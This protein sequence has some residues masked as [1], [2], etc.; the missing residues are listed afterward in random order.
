MKL[1]Q[2]L[3]DHMVAHHGVAADASDDALKS[4]VASALVAGKLSTKELDEMT[5]DA[6][7][8]AKI[9]G[10]V[11]E[12]VTPMFADLT[13]QMEKLVGMATHHTS[14]GK[15]A[16]APAEHNAEKAK[17]AAEFIKAA[18]ID[19]Q[20][21]QAGEVRVK[22]ASE[23]YEDTRS[24]CVWQKAGDVGEYASGK[25]AFIWEGVEGGS[26]GTPR[27]IDHPSRLQEAKGAAY[28]KLM[29]RKQCPE[30]RGRIRIS[31]HEMDLIKETIHE[32][33][34]IGAMMEKGACLNRRKLSDLE[35]KAVLDEA[36][37]SVGAEV[38]PEF[39]DDAIIR[40]PLLHGELAPYVEYVPVTRGSSA[41]SASIG[42]PTFVSTASGTAITPFNTA[43]YVTAFD[44]NFYPASC[45]VQFGN[46]FLEDATPG[47]FNA[48][49][50][51]I[52]EES[53]RWLDEQIAVGDGTT[54][55][56]GIFTASGTAV[57]PDS[58]HTFSSLTYADIVTL[59][60]GINKAA[61]NAFGGSYTRFVMNDP[62]YK[63]LMQ[64]ATGVT[65]DTRPVFGVMWKEYM[66]GD[67]P[68]SVQN[69]ISNGNL[70]LCNLRGYRMYR[71][72][73]LSFITDNV[74][75]THRLADLTTLL[76]RMRWGGKITLAST[77][78]AE[79]TT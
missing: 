43:S 3:R 76:G 59:A 65:G 73:G 60:F 24:G 54:E 64:L 42:T 30:L 35:V 20:N 66:L 15:P 8:K 46:D 11:T 68:V 55:P 29:L 47:F 63:E 13:K 18:A 45:A 62:Q 78:I 31:D 19:S 10:I 25:P 38:V 40:T 39:F 49:M 7:P 33:R 16:A 14:D 50:A 77:F 70:A 28:L 58:S 2:K 26:G 61:R 22:K 9:A 5:A 34:F 48:V 32:H 17:E 51:Q 67:Y 6:D 74:G 79:M 71:R 53:K 21:K 27:Y 44:T 57:T 56:Q 1:T 69:N 75:S 12:V 23:S 52:G 4:A 37:T 36:G 72:R 41:D